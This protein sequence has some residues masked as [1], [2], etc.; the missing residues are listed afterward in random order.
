MASLFPPYGGNVTGPTCQRCGMPLPPNETSC[1]HCGYSTI[2]TSMPPGTPSYPQWGMGAPASGQFSYPGGQIPSYPGAQ[3]QPSYPGLQGWPAY[4]NAQGQP[5]SPGMPAQSSYPETVPPQWGQPAGAPWA[6]PFSGNQ[7]MPP[8]PEHTP[9]PSGY[10]GAADPG[11]SFEHTNYGNRFGETA[12]PTSLAPTAPRKRRSGFKLLAVVVALLL[13]LAAGGVGVFALVHRAATVSG[14]AA[15]HQPSQVAATPTVPPLFSDNFANN[16]HSWDLT[17]V[18]G[19]YSVT[20]SNGQLLLEEDNN[21]IWPEFVPGQTFDNFRLE[22][23]AAITKGTQ[24]NSGFGVYIR[25]SSKANV[26]LAAYYRFALYGNSYYAVFKGSVDAAGQP[27]QEQSL[28]KYLQT[29]ALKPLGQVNHIEII[30]KG[31]TMTLAVNGQTLTSVTDDSYK[32][33]LIALYVSNLAGTQK[34]VTVAFSNLVIYP[35]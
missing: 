2:P 21:H 24:D 33:G 31:A 27:Q 34:G 20:L 26:A 29:T 18:P 10:Y 13:V 7:G 22:V 4:A 8:A 3:S 5:S 17:S 30:A 23:D 6:T 28:V 12:F 35:A 14:T 19:H 25:A 1:R 32:S 15:T 9:F 16:N 11:A